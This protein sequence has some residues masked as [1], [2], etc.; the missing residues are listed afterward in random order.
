MKTITNEFIKQ[1]QG[2]I[3]NAN[4]A[5]KEADEVLK[6]LH[7]YTAKI[8]TKTFFEQFFSKTTEYGRAYTRFSLRVGEKYNDDKVFDIVLGKQVLQLPS[9]GRVDIILAIGDFKAKK[10]TV[11]L[12]YKEKINHLESIYEEE[13]VND[14]RAVYAKHNKPLIW[15]ELLESYD[16]KYMK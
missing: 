11:I 1:Y 8:I 13:L 3:D 4:L 6:A 16:V 9:R 2:Y 12:E 15:S 5:L 14:L 10:E 7:K